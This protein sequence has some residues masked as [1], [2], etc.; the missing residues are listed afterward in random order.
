[1]ME[2]KVRHL[3]R[4]QLK[5]CGKVDISLVMWYFNFDDETVDLVCEEFAKAI[6][7]KIGYN[8]YFNGDSEPTQD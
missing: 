7:S 6:T 2:R 1:M 5:Q 4:K 3:S 8:A